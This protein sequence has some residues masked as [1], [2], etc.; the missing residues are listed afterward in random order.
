MPRFI[1][2]SRFGLIFDRGR[3]RS[4]CALFD[5]RLPDEPEIEES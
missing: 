5:L 1:L 2:T 4:E 3:L